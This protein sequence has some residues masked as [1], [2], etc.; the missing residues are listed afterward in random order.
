M[1]SSK[2][3]DRNLR[4]IRHDGRTDEAGRHSGQNL[5]GEKGLPIFGNYFNDDGLYNPL[6]QHL[7]LARRLPGKLTRSMKNVKIYMLGR[8]PN[9]SA[10]IGDSI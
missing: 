9:R 5:S 8:R 3:R 2:L 7:I 6:D 4:D 1:R 10:V